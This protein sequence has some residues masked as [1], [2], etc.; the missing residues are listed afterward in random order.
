MIAPDRIILLSI[1]RKISKHQEKIDY[2]DFS[3]FT[4]DEFMWMKNNKNI[5]NNIR[6]KFLTYIASHS[7][8]N[9]DLEKMLCKLNLSDRLIR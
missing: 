2:N 5:F 6:K 9:A 8:R 7:S 3:H 4:R 1:I